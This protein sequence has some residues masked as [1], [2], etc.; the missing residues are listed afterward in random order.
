MCFIIPLFA[1]SQT[2]SNNLV[3]RFSISNIIDIDSAKQV[4]Y[5]LLQESMITSCNF[6]DECDCFKL[7]TN[8]FISYNSFKNI[9]YNKGYQLSGDIHLSDGRVLREIEINQINQSNQ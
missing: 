6:I 7:T 3:Y 5:N 9:L 1:S 8:S 4:Q 2:Q